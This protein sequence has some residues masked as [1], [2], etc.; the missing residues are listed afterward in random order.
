MGGSSRSKKLRIQDSFGKDVC[1]IPISDGTTGYELKCRIESGNHQY[2]AVKQRLISPF[3]I[4]IQDGDDVSHFNSGDV[5]LLE[6][7]ENVQCGKISQVAALE[8]KRSLLSRFLIFIFHTII[9]NTLHVILTKSFHFIIKPLK[10]LFVFS[11]NTIIIPLYNFI[12][13]PFNK[14]VDLV[15]Y[16]VAKSISSIFTKME[17]LWNSGVDIFTNVC[18]WISKRLPKLP[19]PQPLFDVITSCIKTPFNLLKREL[20]GIGSLFEALIFN[21]D[22]SIAQ[23][24]LFLRHILFTFFQVDKKIVLYL[25]HNQTFVHCVKQLGIILQKILKF[26]FVTVLFKSLKFLV[27]DIIKPVVVFLKIPHLFVL[28]WRTLVYYCR[29]P[30]VRAGNVSMVINPNL[31]RGYN[32]KMDPPNYYVMNDSTVYSIVLHNKNPRRVK[33]TIELDGK[34]MGVFK[35]EARSKYVIER[36]AFEDKQFQFVA[37]TK[38]LTI[39]SQ[40]GKDI[41]T[42]LIKVTLDAQAYSIQ[43]RRRRHQI[44]AHSS[45][46]SGSSDNSKGEEKLGLRKRV[47]HKAKSFS[48]GSSSCDDWDGPEEEEMGG[49]DVGVL[50]GETKLVGS[51]GQRVDEV[52]D[53]EVERI[54]EL[55]CR[56]VA[57]KD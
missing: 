42:G 12:R 51:S 32:N 10:S 22:S 25:S 41:N 39:E 30:Y 53:F 52:D 57:R 40:S 7:R 55:C 13:P 43:R 19:S 48:F 46:R 36:P 38:S 18:Q 17:S 49:E 31:G 45:A 29:S 54:G 56:L 37:T 27:L 6:V 26:V 20:S 8:Q 11:W 21:Q 44:R 35:L 4:E 5:I 9:Y 23:F 3:G 28:F 16:P 15:L 1:T 47:T 50:M 33:A 24:F 2:A 14:L 34:L